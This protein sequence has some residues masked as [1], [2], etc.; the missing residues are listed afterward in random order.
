FRG[1]QSYTVSYATAAAPNSFVQ[2][3]SVFNNATGATGGEYVNSRAIIASSD[4]GNLATDVTALRFNFGGGLQFGYAGYR[5]IDV[6]TPSMVPEPNV[7]AML[8]IGFGAIG[9]SARYRRSSLATR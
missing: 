7:W 5:E 4:G 8:M 3:A 9:V 6:F 1:G 2:I